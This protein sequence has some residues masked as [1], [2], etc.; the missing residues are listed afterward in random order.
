MVTVHFNCNEQCLEKK[1]K[2]CYRTLQ[3]TK[4]PRLGFEHPSDAEQTTARS[5]HIQPGGNP[6]CPKAILV[7]PMGQDCPCPHPK[8]EQPVGDPGFFSSTATWNV[9]VARGAPKRYTTTLHPLE[10]PG[11]YWSSSR[12]VSYEYMYTEGCLNSHELR[13]SLIVTPWLS[14][15]M[16]WYRRL[17]SAMP[18][19]S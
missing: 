16:L 6:H 9:R 4:L 3:K 7:S 1:A 5:P 8:P 11:L 19:S 10:K 13:T 12:D 2:R 18:P 17:S 15:F 14:H